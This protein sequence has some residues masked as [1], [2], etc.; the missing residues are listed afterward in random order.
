MKA[1]AEWDPCHGLKMRYT[2]PV[3][4]DWAMPTIGT[5]LQLLPANFATVP[6]RSTDA[7]VFVCVEGS[8]QTRIRDQVFTWSPRGCLLYTSP[9][10]RD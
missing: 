10:P 9:S 4:G 7:T 5:C 2:N 6:Y 8:G 3:N 1:H